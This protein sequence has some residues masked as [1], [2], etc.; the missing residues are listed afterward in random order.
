MT[1]TEWAVVRHAMPVPAWLEGRGGQP[2]GYCHRVMLDAIRYVTDNGIKWRSM[3]AD[4]PAWDRVYAFFR[5]WREH[6]L[7]KEFHD[8]LRGRARETEG[9]D[10]EPTAAV[11]GIGEVSESESLLTCPNPNR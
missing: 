9:R 10:P 8:R 3:H 7:V 5:R 11:M 4:F 2:E 1:D 6:G